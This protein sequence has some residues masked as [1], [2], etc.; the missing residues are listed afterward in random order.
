[1]VQE[2]LQEP[3]RS[4]SS[5]SETVD[6]EAVLQAIE[7]N[8]ESIRQLQHLTVSCALS[9]SWPQQKYPELPNC[10]SFYQNIAKLLTHPSKNK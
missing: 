7:A 5:R 6:S 3:Q 9:C 1:M 10:A 8:S 2:I 4:R